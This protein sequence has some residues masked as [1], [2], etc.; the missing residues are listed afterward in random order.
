MASWTASPAFTSYAVIVDEK[1]ADTNGGTFTQDAWQTREINTEV[2]DPDGIVTIA[3]N[4]FTLGA[5]NYL[6]RWQCP[7]VQVERHQTRFFDVTGAA[8]LGSGSSER[9]TKAMTGYPAE[10]NRVTNK[11]FGAQRV[12]PVASNTYRIEHL[13][14]IHI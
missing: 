8:A 12:T 13:S 11:S 9:S 6:I 10:T 5:G 7:A 14:L 4:Q 2:A 3:S 1:T